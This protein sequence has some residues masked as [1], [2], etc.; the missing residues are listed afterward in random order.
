MWNSVGSGENVGGMCAACD[1]GWGER[2]THNVRYAGPHLVSRRCL[3]KKV[4]GGG[5]ELF[6]GAAAQSVPGVGAVAALLSDPVAGRSAVLEWVVGRRRRRRRWS[7][8]EA[9]D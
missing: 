7:P 8:S 4:V 6:P 9:G 3:F 2:F 5:I 1:G